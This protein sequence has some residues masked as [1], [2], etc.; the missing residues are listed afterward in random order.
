MEENNSAQQIASNRALAL[1][2]E[3][4]FGKSAYAKKIP[5]EWIISLGDEEANA[6]LDGILDGDGTIEASTGARVLTTVSVDLAYAVRMLAERLGMNGA[7]TKSGHVFKMR[8]TTP[9]KQWKT[10]SRVE[11]SFYEGPVY[12]LEVEEDES[13][14]V[15]GVA[16][17]NC[18]K[19]GDSF[20][21]QSGSDKC[22]YGHIYRARKEQEVAFNDA[23]KFADQAAR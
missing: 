15:E 20:V 4:W 8:I 19:I 5:M 7:M 10:V 9:E 23:G 21:K 16:V 17:H 18:W 3:H 11:P 12:N 1:T 2:F 22:F 6:L 14:V 13:Y